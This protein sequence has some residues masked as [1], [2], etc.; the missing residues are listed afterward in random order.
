MEQ[1]MKDERNTNARVVGA[2]RL[3]NGY[4]ICITWCLGVAVLVEGQRKA[5]YKRLALAPSQRERIL[6]V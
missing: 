2:A 1:V 5:L 4:Q 3:K 6:G